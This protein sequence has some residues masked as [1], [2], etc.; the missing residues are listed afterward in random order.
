MNHFL[1]INER[2]AYLSDL[3]QSVVN[4]EDRVVIDTEKIVHSSYSLWGLKRSKLLEN[5][6]IKIEKK[7]NKTKV[8]DRPK[9][10]NVNVKQRTICVEKRCWEFM[11]LMSINGIQTLTLLN[12]EKKSKLELFKV[13]DELLPKIIIK[14]I[15][16]ESMILQNQE[17]HKKMVLKLFDVNLSQYRPKKSKEKH[18]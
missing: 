6:A 18:E 14:K 5:R 11:G 10:R 15:K 7:L 17:N 3:N 8:K 2:E 4:I 13:G 12:K 16:G 9:E 1:D